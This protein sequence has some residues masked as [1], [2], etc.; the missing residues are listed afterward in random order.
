MGGVNAEFC[1]ILGFMKS[2]AEGTH[3]EAGRN[4]AEEEKLVEGGNTFAED[5]DSRQIRACDTVKQ[6]IM[7]QRSADLTSRPALRC[8]L[9]KP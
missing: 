4:R 6:G 2:L 7:W 8:P 9:L 5:K 3:D 1:R